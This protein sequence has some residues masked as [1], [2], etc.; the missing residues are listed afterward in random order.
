MVINTKVIKEGI[1]WRAKYR[2][3]KSKWLSPWVVVPHPKNRGG[4]V[5]ES[6]RTKQIN[7][8][9]NKTGYDDVEAYHRAVAVEGDPEVSGHYTYYEKMFEAAVAADPDMAVLKDEISLAESR[10]Q[11]HDTGHLHDYI[12][13]L[14]D[15]INEIK[16][17]LPELPA[18]LEE[19][20]STQYNL[21]SYDARVI[22]AE[23]ETAK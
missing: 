21:G 13:R 9:I 18:Q 23:L 4:E 2:V 7:G 8:R 12:S 14:N 19:R 1:A 22:S 16:K 3:Q 17:T 11:P 6:S 20:L 15:R 5:V 10:L